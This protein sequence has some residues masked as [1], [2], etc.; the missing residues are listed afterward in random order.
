MHSDYKGNGSFVEWYGNFKLHKHLTLFT[1]FDHRWQNT[2]Q[3]Y[4]SKSSY[5]DYATSLSSDSAKINISSISSSLVYNTEKGFNVELGGRINTHSMYGNNLTYTFNPSYLVNNKWKFA[6]NLSSAF[7]APT[8][9]Q[10]YDGFS[11]QPNLKPET[12]VNTE[13]AISFIGTQHFNLSAV[14]FIRNTKNGIDYDYIN[15]KYYNYNSKQEHGIELE[16]RYQF[17][18]WNASFNYTYVNG[19]VNAQNFIYNPATYVYDVKGDTTYAYL[20][21]I[22]KNTLNLHVSYQFNEKLQIAV[23]EKIVDQRF[24]PQYM[25]APIEMPGFQLT[26]F[27]I[28]YNINKKIT[29]NAGLK[30][31]FN[32]QY[33][34]VYGYATRGRNYIIG[35]R[36]GL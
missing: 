3:Y 1:S 30:N 25:S 16:S 36:V 2:D 5:G 13:L 14:G 22:P 24:E 19:N 32:K 35:V 12:S 34:E 4:F 21:R 31:I 23:F 26:D 27:H 11:G 18:K 8:L 33:Q 29:V 10:L 17:K 9:Y 7:K 15:Y 20:T 28:Q 6:F